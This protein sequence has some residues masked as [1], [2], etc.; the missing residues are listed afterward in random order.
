MC[1][2]CTEPGFGKY[3]HVCTDET[4]PENCIF[5]CEFDVD[6]SDGFPDTK[7]IRSGIEKQWRFLSGIKR[8]DYENELKEA[9]K[10]T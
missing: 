1:A 3:L 7:L 5:I 6:N 8:S 4:K 10:N 2:L 9:Q